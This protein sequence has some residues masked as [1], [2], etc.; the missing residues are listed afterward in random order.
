MKKKLCILYSALMLTLLLLPGGLLLIGRAG[1]GGHENRTLAQVPTLTRENFRE[2]PARFDAYFSDHFALRED[3]VTALNTLTIAVF[4]DTLDDKVVV[5]QKGMLF[6]S[7]ANDDYLRRETL[8][9]ADAAQA[10]QA[11]SALA[12]QAETLGARFYF[13]VAP[14]K[15]SLYPEAMPAYYRPGPG[16]KN[17]QRLKRALEAEGVAYIDLEAALRACRQSDDTYPLYYA[18]DTH[19]NDYGALLAYRAI[20]A[21]IAEGAPYDAY[22]DA[23]IQTCWDHGGDLHDMLLPSL[24]GH[25]ARLITPEPRFQSARRIDPDRDVQF[26]TDSDTNALRLMMF[27]DSFG[28][29]LYPY[30]S[31][32]TGH[33]WYSSAF[34]YTLTEA[35]EEK[36]DVILIEIAERNLPMLVR[37]GETQP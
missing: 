30:L 32:N 23:G 37:L 12:A 4:A 2:F 5:G 34:P 26:S 6:F 20:M 18:Q 11:L 10:A 25:N 36:P 16:E 1:A 17:L 24:P 15:S 7:A 22:D 31:A 8:S 3:M 21:Q 19:W 9:Q 13:T 14:N 27:R 33:A 29:A 28:K 35:A